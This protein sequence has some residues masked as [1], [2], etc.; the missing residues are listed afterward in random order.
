MKEKHPDQPLVLVGGIIRF[1]QNK[2][3][4][5]LLEC[6]REGKK[7]DLNALWILYHRKLFSIEDMV[8][9]YQLIGYSVSGFGDISNFPK[10]TIRKFDE[11][12]AKMV[13][14]RKR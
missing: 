14:K 1:K 10:K 11:L 5:F 4:D 13:A 6:A 2:V 7:F 8:Q 12:A 9:L 3:V